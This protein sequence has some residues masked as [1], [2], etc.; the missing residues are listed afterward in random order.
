MLEKKYKNIIYFITLAII[1]TIA[2]QVYWNVKNYEVNKQQV[3]NQIQASFDN[4]VEKYFAEIAKNDVFRTFKSNSGSAKKMEIS[5][6]NDKYTSEVWVQGIGD[7]IPRKSKEKLLQP[8]FGHTEPIILKELDSS[9]DMN[10]I[11]IFKNK[12]DSLDLRQFTSKILFSFIMDDIKLKE[13]DSLLSFEL[14]RKNITLQYGLK[15]IDEN[16]ITVK[17]YIKT[18]NLENF[19]GKFESIVSN[20]P[21]VNTHSTLELRYINST[22]SILKRMLGSLLLS[23]L[24]SGIIIGC[25]LF[26]LNT[27]SNQKQ[28][29][30]VKNDLISNITHEFKTPIATIG[31][32]IE[33]IKNFNVI[34]NKQK[35]N[36]YLDISNN[37]LSKLNFMVEKLLETATLDSGNLELNKDKVNV[38]DL[39]Q[40]LVD[41]FQ[42]QS[43]EKII[44]YK[45]S[46]LPVLANVDNFH[47]ENAINNILDNAIKYGGNDVFVNLQQQKNI[48]TIDISDSGNSLSKEQSTQIFE[49]FYR[50]PKGNTHDIKGFGIGLYYCKKII[51]EHKGIIE[52]ELKNR[53]TTFKI[54]LPNE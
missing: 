41:K 46:E 54:S 48:F 38:S 43:N 51:E 36:N 53:L 25:L 28:L 24:L 49:K 30:E 19:S 8:T 22:T 7:S 34:D 26:L 5:I 14:Q 1:A 11:A 42:L 20:S 31:V 39:V 52:L 6:S 40:T 15:L 37:Q 45:K 23:L 17:K 9:I 47:F 32:A 35:T 13:I 18:S 29:A 27:I 4:A 3:T 10:Q 33:S 16:P 21:F 50:V 44:T 2:A 12:I